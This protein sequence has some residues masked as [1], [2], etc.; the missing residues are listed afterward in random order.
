[1]WKVCMYSKNVNNRIG[2]VLIICLISFYFFIFFLSLFNSLPS[3]LLIC[4][5]LSN[6]STVR[7]WFTG[8]HSQDF[9][10]VPVRCV[11]RVIDGTRV[12]AC[13]HN[14]SIWCKHCAIEILACKVMHTHTFSVSRT[15]PNHM[16]DCDTWWDC[17]MV[18]SMLLMFQYVFNLFIFIYLLNIKRVNPQHRRRRHT[19]FPCIHSIFWSCS[20]LFSP[21][22]HF[23]CY[24]L[25]YAVKTS[26]GD[27]RSMIMLT[28]RVCLCVCVL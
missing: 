28:L 14:M 2:F 12:S 3:S 19:H 20:F 18:G 6:H 7:P 23:L 4:I 26:S 22:A 24:F 5:D 27:L 17:S 13:M 10:K 15:R 21:S 1:M 25:Q 11:G 9:I 16:N 8:R